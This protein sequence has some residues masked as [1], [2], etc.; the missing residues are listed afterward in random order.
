MQTMDAAMLK[1][2]EE[3]VADPRAAYDRAVRKEL[4]EPH[5]K[6]AGQAV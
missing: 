6:A 4:F 1:L 3:G 5:L 2:V